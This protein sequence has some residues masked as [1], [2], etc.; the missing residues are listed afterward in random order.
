MSIT[1]QLACPHCHTLNRVP[2]DRLA[3]RPLCGR[4]RKPLF[5]GEPATLGV[6]SFGAHLDRSELPLL[7]DF[8]APWCGPCRVMAPQFQ[9]AAA[10]LEP[11]VRLAKVDTQSE[12]TLGQRHGIRSIPTMVLFERGRELAR[13]SGALSSADIVRW[14]QEQLAGRE[15]R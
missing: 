3:Q 8:W 2:G 14:T 9:K 15:R 1:T 5:E 12:P 7:V 13:V 10:Q 6:D 4:C 11:A